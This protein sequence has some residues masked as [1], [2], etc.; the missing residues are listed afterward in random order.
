MSK[1]SK[2]HEIAV[3]WNSEYDGTLSCWKSFPAKQE[4]KAIRYAKRQAKKRPG[5]KFFVCDTR[6]FVGWISDKTKAR[7]E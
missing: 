6:L 1:K 4:K 2:P 3:M 7:W 5:R